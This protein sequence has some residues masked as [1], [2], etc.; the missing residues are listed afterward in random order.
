MT[1]FRVQL[2]TYLRLLFTHGVKPVAM[3]GEMPLPPQ[4]HGQV[5]GQASQSYQ[6]PWEGLTV[7]DD[8]S[9]NGYSG[10]MSKDVAMVGRA[11]DLEAAI[12]TFALSIALGLIAFLFRTI[13]RYVAGLI[14]NITRVIW[15][16]TSRFDCVCLP[17]SE[18]EAFIA[19]L[20][21]NQSP[22]SASQARVGG[23]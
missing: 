12:F 6:P 14:A 19:H 16:S 22:P 3:Y 11:I 5:V 18:M 17:T 20:E 1:I 15:L 2:Y 9:K 4:D 8:I 21:Q 13:V 23:V 10:H 7:H